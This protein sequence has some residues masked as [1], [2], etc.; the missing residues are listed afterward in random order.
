MENKT[1]NEIIDTEIK[2][3]EIIKNAEK[4]SSIINDDCKKQCQDILSQAVKAAKAEADDMLNKAQKSGQIKATVI[5]SEYDSQIEKL[6]Q[7]ANKNS[8]DAI[9]AVISSIMQI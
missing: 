4:K 8:E 5:L 1:V 7:D 2:A 6:K 3:A 9:K